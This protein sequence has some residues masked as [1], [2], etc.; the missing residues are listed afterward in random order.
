MRENCNSLKQFHLDTDSGLFIAAIS[1]SRWRFWTFP[2]M[3]PPLKIYLCLFCRY[4]TVAVFYCLGAVISNSDARSFSDGCCFLVMFVR[5]Q[6]KSNPT[7][8][9]M[10]LC[11]VTQKQT[12]SFIFT[13]VMLYRKCF[14]C[15]VSRINGCFILIP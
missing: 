2:L 8:Q 15:S 7:S 14:S 1:R 13:D 12:H 11:Y 10:S 4:T 9:W 5:V 6:Y 3:Q